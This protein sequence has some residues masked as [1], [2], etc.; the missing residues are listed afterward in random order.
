MYRLERL[1]IRIPPLRE[2]S[3]DIMLLARTFLDSGRPIGTHCQVS[4][5][6]IHAVQHYEGGERR[7]EGG[8]RKA[9]D[10]GRR[11]EGRNGKLETGP[12]R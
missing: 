12:S 4:K 1:C 10:G 7:T 11:T 6:F 2:R 9:E 8:E 5:G 3:D